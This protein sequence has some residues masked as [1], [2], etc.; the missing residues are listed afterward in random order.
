MLAR[1]D[2]FT[3]AS[4]GY[5]GQNEGERTEYHA[6]VAWGR[7]AEICGQFL[8]RGSSL[9]S[10]GDSRPAAGMTTL[11]GAYFAGEKPVLLDYS[12][13]EPQEA[14]ADQAARTR[15]TPRARDSRPAAWWALDRIFTPQADSAARFM[16]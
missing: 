7:L 2:T 9:T 3:L 1:V 8:G 16:P 13:D 4:N 5:S 10:R 15:P 6:C 14:A 12:L 11:K